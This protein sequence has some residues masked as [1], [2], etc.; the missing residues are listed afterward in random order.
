[1]AEQN[2]LKQEFKGMQTEHKKQEQEQDAALQEMCRADVRQRLTKI[3]TGFL[4]A[5]VEGIVLPEEYSG[6]FSVRVLENSTYEVAVYACLPGRGANTSWT[7]MHRWS[8][9]IAQLTVQSMKVPE[10]IATKARKVEELKKR[11][12]EEQQVILDQIANIATLLARGQEAIREHTELLM[13]Q[14]VVSAIPEA[15][16][17][18]EQ[19]A[20]AMLEQFSAAQSK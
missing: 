6:D 18:L 14:S 13:L 8:D 12:K 17:Q 5:G 20:A 10:V 7:Q 16:Q 9:T 1:M 2:E 19:L 3:Y 4:E 15:G 11:N